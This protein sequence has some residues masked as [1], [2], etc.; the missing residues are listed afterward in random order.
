MFFPLSKTVQC[1]GPAEEHGERP[2]EEQVPRARSSS[3]GKVKKEKKASAESASLRALDRQD[4]SDVGDDFELPPGSVKIGMKYFKKHCLQCHSIYPDNR[5]TYSGQYNVGPTL[6]NVCGRASGEYDMFNKTNEY[7]VDSILWTD[8]ALM[9]Y[10]KNPR[11][12]AGAPMQMNFAGISN[13]Q[14][15]V[16]II[17]YLHTLNWTNEKLVNPPPRPQGG[18]KRYWNIM[19]G[20]EKDRSWHEREQSHTRW[21][22][23]K[24][25]KGKGATHE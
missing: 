9:N 10:M 19:T 1:E 11:K 21:E 24:D 23:Y 4:F 22:D 18:L 13:Y 20:K 16:D 14:I 6:F 7:R 12:L 15:R 25:E 2:A 3:Q 5:I 17:H 8:G